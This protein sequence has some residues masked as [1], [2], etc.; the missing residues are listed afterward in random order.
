MSELRGVVYMMKR[1]GPRTEPRG[2]NFRVYTDSM[3][4]AAGR[5]HFDVIC[6][7]KVINKYFDKWRVTD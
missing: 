6:F 1:R 4:L 7:D 3:G 5:L 2:T